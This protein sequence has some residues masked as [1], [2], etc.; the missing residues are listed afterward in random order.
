MAERTATTART[1][2]TKLHTRARAPAQ[3]HDARQTTARTTSSTHT[4]IRTS[5]N[6]LTDGTQ[7]ELA[8]CTNAAQAY[9]LPRTSPTQPTPALARAFCAKP[10]HTSVP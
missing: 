1:S 7:S 4:S 6:L 5:T 3:C 10:T 9:T 2:S 8:R